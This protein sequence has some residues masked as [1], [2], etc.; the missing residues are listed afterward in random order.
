MKIWYKYLSFSVWKIIM[1]PLDGLN[2]SDSLS[3]HFDCCFTNK[4]NM[5]FNFH[6][7]FA[8]SSNLHLNNRFNI[9]DLKDLFFFQQN[10]V[11]LFCFGVLIYYVSK[12][13]LYIYPK[14]S[15]LVLEIYYNFCKTRGRT[16][17]CV[18][19]DILSQ[20]YKVNF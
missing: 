5:F 7:F 6:G 12:N 20:P 16:V 15:N 17:L 4:N 14:T 19:W 2:L 3:L 13:R 1:D 10:D 8:T 11:K 9:W 18:P